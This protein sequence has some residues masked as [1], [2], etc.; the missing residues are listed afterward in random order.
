MVT[1]TVSERERLAADM[2]AFGRNAR[3]ADANLHLLQEYLDRFI[4]VDDGKVVGVADEPKELYLR[5]WD[6]R[7]VHITW[8][9][10]PDLLW[11][12]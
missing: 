12:L 2:E 5:F 7:D 3:W 1:S 9:G 6:R 10:P 11:V 4:A 8:V